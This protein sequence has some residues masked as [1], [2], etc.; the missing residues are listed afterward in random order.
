MKKSLFLS[1][2]LSVMLCITACNI[3]K[4][5]SSESQG[6]DNS[7]Q[8]MENYRYPVL[9]TGEVPAIKENISKKALEI[10]NSVRECDYT[11]EQI[12][13]I[14][15]RIKNKDYSVIIDAPNYRAI[16]ICDLDSDGTAE[17]LTINLCFLEWNAKLE[18]F[19]VSGGKMKKELYYQVAE[20]YHKNESI[21]GYEITPFDRFD[22]LEVSGDGHEVTA[23]RTMWDDVYIEACRVE[24]GEF[25][26]NKL[27]QKEYETNTEE[28]SAVEEFLE[29][30]LTYND[31]M[32]LKCQAESK[33]P[34]VFNN[35]E[36]NVGSSVE[37]AVVCDID[38]D[39]EYEIALIKNMLTAMPNRELDVYSLRDGVFYHKCGF[40]ETSEISEK[41]AYFDS[42]GV[43][44]GGTNVIFYNNENEEQK[45]G[46]SVNNVQF[47]F[48]EDE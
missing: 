28:L 34:A 27:E 23:Y 40:H 11:T 35:G 14:E 37:W 33:T 12:S 15:E 41:I 1:L 16:A 43:S 5:D 9:V 45:L 24:N 4:T 44:D 46:V 19:D 7:S 22:R 26:F 30:G 21:T 8:S 47:I 6:S 39:G 36:P 13:E 48:T 20:D 42:V 2:L 10:D 17:A 3:Q 38:S 25:V 31:Y 18:L 29:Q 32:S